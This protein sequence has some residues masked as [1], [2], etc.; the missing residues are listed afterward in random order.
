MTESALVPQIQYGLVGK[1]LLI[2]NKWLIEH[3]AVLGAAFCANVGCRACAKVHGGSGSSGQPPRE[4]ES[5]TK[6]LSM[7][8]ELACRV[9]SR[10]RMVRMSARLALLV[11]TRA[12]QLL[13]ILVWMGPSTIFRMKWTHEWNPGQGKKAELTR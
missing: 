11:R 5:K 4:R 3:T 10:F 7:S 13:L 12:W 1:T 8:V 2:S 9:L 6:T